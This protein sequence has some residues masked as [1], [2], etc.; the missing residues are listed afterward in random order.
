MDESVACFDCNATW[1]SNAQERVVWKKPR[2]HYNP[3]TKIQRAFKD[4]RLIHSIEV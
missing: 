3:R 4:I 2:F 1:V